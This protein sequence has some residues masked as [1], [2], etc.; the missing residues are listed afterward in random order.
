MVII[1]KVK[2]TKCGK[3]QK[4]ELRKVQLTE[5]N[6]PVLNNK[7]KTC[8]WCEKSFKIDKDNILKS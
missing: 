3:S 4:M 8:V 2:C 7:R 1:I 5:F 6:K